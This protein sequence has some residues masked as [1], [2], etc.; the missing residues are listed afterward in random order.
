[1]KEMLQKMK[2]EAARV[3]ASGEADLVLGWVKGPL[4]WQSYPA[5]IENEQATASLTWDPFC[6]PNLSKYLLEE[7]W[8]KQKVA[9]FLKGCDALGF[10]QLLQDKRVEREKVLIF[11]IPCS[12]LVDPQK[13]ERAG[14]HQGLLSVEQQGG[15]LVFNYKNEQKKADPSLFY[16]DKCLSCRYPNPVVYDMLLGDAV[17]VKPRSVSRGRRTGTTGRK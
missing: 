10:N 2:T 3:L 13:V 9:L 11:G 8:V 7:L 17:P 14:L 16:Y 6:V 5:F 15:E 4:W 12:G 1:V